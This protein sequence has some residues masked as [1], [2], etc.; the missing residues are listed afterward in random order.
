LPDPA[1]ST[2]IA[3][4]PELDGS[5]CNEA[6]E[7]AVA[8]AIQLKH[9]TSKERVALLRKWYDLTLAALDDLATIITAENGKPLTEAQG[10][11]IYAADFL[12][13][14]SGVGS[15][16]DGMVSRFIGRS[17]RLCDLTQF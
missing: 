4:L 7:G 17:P 8:A 5:R 6:V 3:V 14:F 16:I 13:W 10:E 1:T 11:V 12:D 15:R 2:C 9:L